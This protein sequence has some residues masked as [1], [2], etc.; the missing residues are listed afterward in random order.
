MNMKTGTLFFE[1]VESVTS[2]EVNSWLKV[3]R[4]RGCGESKIDNNKSKMAT[5]SRNKR[6][7]VVSRLH[8]SEGERR[9]RILYLRVPSC[10]ITAARLAINP[11]G[12][13]SAGLKGLIELPR[14]IVA[15]TA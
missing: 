15:K 6:K 8:F 7:T 13:I 10:A 1:K 9:E 4:Q 14:A 3:E 5:L 2:R 12:K 11:L